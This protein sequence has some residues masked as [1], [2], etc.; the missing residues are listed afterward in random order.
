[1]AAVKERPLLSPNEPRGPLGLRVGVPNRL[2][3][4]MAAVE[5]DRFVGQVS[6][7]LSGPPR[8]LVKKG[9]W[10]CCGAALRWACQVALFFHTAVVENGRFFAQ[11]SPRACWAS[12]GK[13]GFAPQ[14]PKT[15]D[16][17]SGK[18]STRS[19]QWA[20]RTG[21]A[22]SRRSVRPLYGA[23]MPVLMWARICGTLVDYST[24]RRWP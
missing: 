24:H 11:V 18:L 14:P 5:S 13:P 23:P 1:M 15:A 3:F 21:S 2:V 10:A 22:L 4:H 6:P 7:G 8:V 9:H 16:S 12:R 19:Q 20:P 17:S